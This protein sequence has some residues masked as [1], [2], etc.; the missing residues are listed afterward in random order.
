MRRSFRVACQ[1]ARSP[2]WG[3]AGRV[4]APA[5]S[6]GPSAPPAV[7]GAERERRFG[8]PPRG[9]PGSRHRRQRLRRHLQGDR[10]LHDLH[11]GA[12]RRAEGDRQAG[13]PVLF[14]GAE[15]EQA[16][17]AQGLRGPRRQVGEAASRAHGEAGTA[18]FE[19]DQV[20]PV[21][22]A[23]GRGE[24]EPVVG[25]RV[26][27]GAGEG[28]EARRVVR[29]PAAGRLRQ[30]LQGLV[31][32]RSQSVIDGRLT[33]S[34]R[35]EPASAGNPTGGRPQVRPPGRWCSRGGWRLGE[36]RHQ[37]GSGQP[38]TA[39]GAP[40]A[41]R[42]DGSRAAPRPRRRRRGAAR[43]S[44]SARRRPSPA[45]G[46]QHLLGR[47]LGPDPRSMSPCGRPTA[48]MSSSRSRSSERRRRGPV[49]PRAGRRRAAASARAS[50]AG[51]ASSRRSG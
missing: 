3:G 28:V 20:A 6:A 30:A 24:A 23:P 36:L 17:G 16:L 50:S 27:G 14:R 29:R 1:R 41:V 21:V 44:A 47:H 13:S 5:R 43:R 39:G 10:H 33:L 42:G 2:G 19:A 8:R 18:R 4:S 31:E 12:P 45:V 38:P 26:L 25:A 7:E 40:C 32:L 11:A 48:S 49:L 15:E 37:P 34:N 35:L 22:G 51:R 9:V 46:E